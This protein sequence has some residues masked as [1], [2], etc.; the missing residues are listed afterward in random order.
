MKNSPLVSVVMPAFNRAK[1]IGEAMESIRKQTFSNWELLIVD[2]GSTDE[3]FDIVTRVEQADERLRVIRL[4]QNSGV[5]CALNIGFRESRGQFIARLD[6]DDRA[7]VDRIAAQ[8]HAFEQSDRLVAVGS[9]VRQFGEVPE[10]IVPFPL[11]DAEAKAML[12]TASNALI[13]GSIMVR[14]AFIERQQIV[15]DESLPVAED[16]DY[17]VSIMERNGVIGNVDAPLIDYRVYAQ[18]TSNLHGALFAPCV[19]KIRL[20]LLAL[21][22]PMLH[23]GD[24]DL[25]A[26]MFCQPFVPDIDVLLETCRSVGRMLAV[27]P[28]SYG[29]DIE[30]VRQFIAV[31]LQKMAIFYRDRQLYNRFHFEEVRRELSGLTLDALDVVC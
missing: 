7:S 4:G 29:Q 8:L 20:R 12:I 31:F 18:N 6:S 3:T 19:L 27:E 2:D 5:S 9:H 30:L 15:F 13:G 1:F 14:R 23:Q 25:V 16:L 10:G 11:S 28:V 21:W 17:L 26:R 24:R 22:F